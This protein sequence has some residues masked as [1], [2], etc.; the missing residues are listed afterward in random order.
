[1]SQSTAGLVLNYTYST[2]QAPSTTDSVHAATTNA[3]YAVHDTACR[4]GFTEAAYNFQT[5]ERVEVGTIGVYM[6]VQNDPSN[7]DGSLSNNII[8]HETTYGITTRMIS[9]GTGRGRCL[10]GTETR[11][12]GEGV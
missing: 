11:G 5:L 10:Q 4:Y 6:S 12:P 3:F 1:M 9:G 7:R 2:P 8:V